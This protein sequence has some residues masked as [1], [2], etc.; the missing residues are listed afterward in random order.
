MT[1]VTVPELQ[2]A[3]RAIQAGDFVEPS[4]E[5]VPEWTPDG[6]VVP[7]LGVQ[8]QCGAST[9]ALALATLLASARVVECASGPVC[10]LTGASVRELGPCGQGW[11]RGL[12]DGVVIDRSHEIRLHAAEVPS[13]APLDRPVRWTIIDVGWDPTHVLVGTS[14]LSA[15]VLRSGLSVVVAEMSVP[16]LRRL[17]NTLSLLPDTAVIAAVVGPPVKRWPKQVSGSAGV[18]VR[19]L[20]DDDRLV[21]VPV[22]GSLRLAGLTPDPLPTQLLSAAER[23]VRL[24]E[25]ISPLSSESRKDA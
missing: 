11:T 18:L 25:L 4:A 17:E 15:L 9:L 24:I 5:P 10:G 12:R 23:I 22:V 21:S 13:P 20:I 3:W 6:P 1:A 16:G 8:G 2:R 7:V 14:W 19:Q